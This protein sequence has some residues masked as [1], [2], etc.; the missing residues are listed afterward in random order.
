MANPAAQ[1][2]VFTE[3]RAVINYLNTG[4]SANFAGDFTFPGFTIGV[5]ENNFVTEA[6]GV[7]TIPVSGI[8][9]F[10]VNSDDG[11]RVTIGTNVLSY[12]SPRSP[13]DS[14]ATFNLPAGDYPV[15]LVFYECGGG[16]EVEFFAVSGA[17]SAFNTSFRL[18]GDTANG[19]VGRLNAIC[20]RVQQASPITQRVKQINTASSPGERETARRRPAVAVALWATRELTQITP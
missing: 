2:A 19:K 4:P 1:A 9:T 20:N 10:G 3:N 5:D 12:P 11:F 14:V 17:Y 15:R 6:T 7:I 13:G 16:A 18:V 8:W